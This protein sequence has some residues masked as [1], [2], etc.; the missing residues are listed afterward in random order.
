MN[1]VVR[2]P[3]AKRDLIQIG[4][5]IAQDSVSSAV[6]F[7]RSARSDMRKLAE[8]PGMDARRDFEDARLAELRSW[9]IGGFRNYLIFYL[10]LSDGIEVVR[11]LHGAR[12]LER[13][14]RS[15]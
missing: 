4:R 1:R 14:F 6:R 10:P 2:R 3:Q 15:R 8:M 9:P 7:L 5:Y 12:D 13:I 11:V